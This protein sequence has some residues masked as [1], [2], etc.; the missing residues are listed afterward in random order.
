M[1]LKTDEGWHYERFAELARHCHEIIELLRSKH[2]DLA[3][4]AQEAKATESKA[5]EVVKQVVVRL[6]S[7][8]RLPP[9]VQKSTVFDIIHKI[10][11]IAD[12]LEKAAD[13]M[14]RFRITP[15]SPINSMLNLIE[16]SINELSGAI[17]CLK[18]KNLGTQFEAHCER[19][20]VLESEAD[21]VN[22]PADEDLADEE[23]E[24]IDSFG[25]KEGTPSYAEIAELENTLQ[26]ARRLG[27]IMGILEAAV[28]YCE[29]V[30]DLLET[31]KYEIE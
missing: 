26:H 3:Q 12:E 29:D 17:D 28:D 25:K 31:L 9:G 7:A 6:R 13:R 27:R 8:R 23:D 11:D 19:M 1:V 20:K 15:N 24:A 22:R 16:E 4:K 30:S 10:D 21:R 5:D 18:N 14:Q 2:D